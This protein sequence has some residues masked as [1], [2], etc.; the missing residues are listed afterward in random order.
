MMKKISLIVSG[1]VAAVSIQAAEQ[2]NIVYMMLDEWGYYEMSNL[3]HPLLETPNMDQF[4]KEGMRFT[5]MLAGSVVCAPT[6]A[7]LMLGKHSGHT[8]VRMNSGSTPIR[9]EDVT[10]A[11]VIKDAG[12]AVGG[13]GKWGIGD[14]GTEGVP[15]K[16]GFDIFY[17]YYN[18]GHAHSYYPDCLIKNSELVPLKGNTNHAFKGETFSQYL[19]HDEA[20]KFIR[21]HAG[22]RPF[23][24]YLPYTPPHAYYG[25][26]ENDP[27]YLKYK[28]K[29][30]DA[31]PHHRNPKVAP[32][33]EAHRYAAFVSMMD[34]QLGE[35][36]AILKEAGVDDN[37]IVILTGDNGG[38]C[39]PFTSKKYPHGFFGPNKDP[40]TGV[41]FRLGKGHVYEGGLRVA[42]LVRWPGKIKANSTSDHLGY[43]PDAFP[44]LATLAGAQIPEDIDGISFLPTLL[45]QDDQQKKHDYLYWEYKGQVAV[46]QGDW[47]LITDSEYQKKELYNLASDV[48]ESNNIAEQHPEIVARLMGLAKESHIPEVNGKILDKSKMWK[49]KNKPKAYL[50]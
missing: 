48:S 41:V 15:E 27:D 10:L 7:T 40:K 13:F 21:E 24:A 2:P 20:K 19:I 30:W 5:Q 23:F 46:R 39:K 32:P 8:S 12:Y 4:R 29:D 17:G 9:A 44:T 42:Y 38:S 43:F 16:H 26:P 37:T 25:I 36:L 45:G 1:L 14:R 49:G 47:K 33:D 18:Q 28:D 34:R 6:R 22:K 31:P 3:G 35:I 11:K 50:E